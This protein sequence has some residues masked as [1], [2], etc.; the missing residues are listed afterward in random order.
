MSQS[1]KPLLIPGD[2]TKNLEGADIDH[3]FAIA[4]GV[5]LGSFGAR[6]RLYRA[7]QVQILR[8]IGYAEA[9]FWD[10]KEDP[11][12]GE[13]LV[14]RVRKMMHGEVTAFIEVDFDL[15]SF[16]HPWSYSSSRRYS[17]EEPAPYN[18]I[19][20]IR[21]L[22]DIYVIIQKFNDKKTV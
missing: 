1:I 10:G 3:A 2:I 16:P 14:I 17:Y 11:G 5:I 18:K 8:D 6:Y 15:R 22:E 4:W 19:F 7:K 13:G 21:K 20:T 9:V 12:V